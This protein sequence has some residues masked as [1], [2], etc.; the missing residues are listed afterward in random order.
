MVR[1][2]ARETGYRGVSRVEETVQ[3]R[4]Q[5]DDTREERASLRQHSEEGDER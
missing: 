3:G 5:C 1:G 4:L 2:L